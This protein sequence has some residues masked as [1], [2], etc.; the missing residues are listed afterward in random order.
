MVEE[1]SCFQSLPT[2]VMTFSLDLEGLKV[3]RFS[4]ALA[5]DALE[6]WREV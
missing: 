1:I 2:A 6:D 5:G 4:N 3:K